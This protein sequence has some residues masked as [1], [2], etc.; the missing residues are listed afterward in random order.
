MDLKIIILL[1]LSISFAYSS[2][3]ILSTNSAG[4]VLSFF[5]HQTIQYLVGKQSLLL[6]DK[7]SP[8]LPKHLDL[9]LSPATSIWITEKTVSR[10]Y[11]RSQLDLFSRLDDVWNESFLENLFLSYEGPDQATIEIKAYEF[12]KIRGVTRVFVSDNFEPTLHLTPPIFRIPATDRLP[13]GPFFIS[14]PERE[15]TVVA[16]HYVY[17]LYPD[18]YDGFIFGSILDIINGGWMPINIT[19]TSSS[20]IDD[21][22]PLLIPVPSRIHMPSIQNLPLS[23]TRFGLK[24]IYDAKGL[25]TA[26]GSLAYLQT[27]DIPTETA[28]SIEKL[29]ELGA[30]MVGKTRTSQFAHGAHPWEF[31]DVAYSWNPRGDGHLTASAS[32]SGS[33]C[34][35]AAYEWLD[36]TVGS[37]TRGSVRKPAALVG[38]YGI[39]PSHGSMDLRGVMPLSEEMDTAGFFARH[40]K[41]FHE[42]ATQWYVMVVV[43]VSICTYRKKQV[44]RFISR[45]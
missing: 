4:T 43:I 23:G 36:F 6:I 13:P 1:F 14:R 45:E 32:S 25:P 16:V 5:D 15:Q 44:F 38:V 35:I 37:D 26:A 21:P 33:A 24:D 22:L 40:P 8:E 12:L 41:I 2:F 31:R 3:E 7:T 27:H 18:E 10:E 29:L 34:A 11:L 39:R 20:Q 42:V 30:V 19:Q 17:R 28:P 9:Q